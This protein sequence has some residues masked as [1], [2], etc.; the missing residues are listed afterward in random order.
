MDVRPRDGFVKVRLRDAA[1]T[2]ATIDLTDGRVLHVGGRGDAFLEKLHSGEI[3]GSRGLLLSDAAAIALII[4][5]ITGIWLWLAPRL[6]RATGPK[7][8]AKQ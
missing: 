2:E 5:L 3:F 6:P 8:A 4:A 7:D 1:S